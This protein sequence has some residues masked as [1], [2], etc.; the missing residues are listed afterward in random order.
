LIKGF[1]INQT[2]ASQQM[3]K[4]VA[5]AKIALLDFPLQRHRMQL[6][7]QVLVTDPAKLE[8]IRQRE[9]DI[10]K[11]KI[12]KIVAAGANVILTTKTIDDLCM[13]YMVEAGVIGVRRVR[14][15]DLRR[16]SGATG[17]VIMPNL[18]DLEGG[19]SFDVANLGTAEEVAEERVGDG[20]ILIIRGTKTSKS[21]TVLLRGANEFLLDEMDRSLHD[22]LCVIQRVLESKSL[23]GTFFEFT[24]VMMVPVTFNVDLCS[25][26]RRC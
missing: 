18:A 7:V 26:W 1:A 6:G 10:T 14:K 16:L 11:E 24:C 13:K 4:L 25:W 8:A 12:A 9:C 17:G 5:N 19:E 3:P 15:E 23:V 2:R 21:V 22:V 20:D